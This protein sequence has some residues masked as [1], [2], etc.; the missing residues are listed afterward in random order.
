[1]ADID[2]V[3]EDRQRGVHTARHRVAVQLDAGQVVM[4]DE[5]EVERC[6]W[7]AATRPDAHVTEDRGR[8]N[9]TKEH[10]EHQHEQPTRS[11][12][13][14]LAL[15]FESKMYGRV[16]NAISAWRGQ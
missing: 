5:L 7:C 15:G 13:A 2:V 14:P 1:V 4:S 10:R 12:R 11:H 3:V 8:Q 9:D 6:S 16:S